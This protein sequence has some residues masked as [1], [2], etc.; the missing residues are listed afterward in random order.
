MAI[1]MSQQNEAKQQERA[2]GMR[3]K[4]LQKAASVKEISLSPSQS[5][6]PPK[7][8]KKGGTMNNIALSPAR[9]KVLKEPDFTP[10]KLEKAG[11]LKEISLS[12]M[13]CKLQKGGSM[14]DLSPVREK[15]T[16]YNEHSYSP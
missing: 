8:L 14:K 10:P 9:E 12:P 4:L 2:K 11:T 6:S 1:M 5:P 13:G 3:D 15:V 16:S 7:L